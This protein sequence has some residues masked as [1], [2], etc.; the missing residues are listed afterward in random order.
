[1]HYSREQIIILFTILPV[2][3]AAIMAAFR[4]KTA[5]GPLRLLCFLIFFALVT[6]SLS[7][8]LWFFQTSNLFLWPIYITVEF[9]LILWIYS[10]VLENAFLQ[11]TRVRIIVTFLVIIM[12]RSF[13][14]SGKSVLIDNSGRL[15]ESIMVIALVLAYYYK[16]FKE[17]I[18]KFLWREP[19]FWISNGLF[20]FFSGNFLIFIFLNY[21]LLY[22]KD[23]NDKIW[24]IHA[25]LNYLLYSVYTYALWI[26]RKK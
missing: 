14:L 8:L 17:L 18:V 20:L 25:F 16:L 9:G 15:I 5:D 1:M 21:I 10:L 11:Q 7:R 3:L 22:S 4:F 19:F 2:F 12:I 13:Y 26:S 24:V 23:L 6:E